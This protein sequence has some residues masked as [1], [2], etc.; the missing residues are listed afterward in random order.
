[1]LQPTAPTFDFHWISIKFTLH[2]AQVEFSQDVKMSHPS[3]HWNIMG[4]VDNIK[5]LN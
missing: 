5:M 1:L 4:N 3:R 2:D